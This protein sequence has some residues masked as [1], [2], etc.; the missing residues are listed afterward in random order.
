MSPHKEVAG[1]GL[2]RAGISLLDVWRQNRLSA[3]EGIMAAC[4]WQFFQNE[5]NT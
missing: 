1:Q 2:L 3:V 5:A 4:Q